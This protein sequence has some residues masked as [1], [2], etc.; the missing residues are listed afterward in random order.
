[1]LVSMI[2]LTV[3]LGRDRPSAVTEGSQCLGSW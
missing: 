1:M 3:R 2:G